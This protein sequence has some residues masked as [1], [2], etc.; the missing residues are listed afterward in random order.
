MT[1]PSDNVQAY[2]DSMRFPISTIPTNKRPITCAGMCRFIADWS[3]WFY[4]NTN[5][6]DGAL[7]RQ[8]AYLWPAVVKGNQIEVVPQSAIVKRLRQAGVPASNAIW[9][10]IDVVSGG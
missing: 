10:Y 4:E 8:L 7:G 5:S 3:D 6:F 1:S 9:N 2:K